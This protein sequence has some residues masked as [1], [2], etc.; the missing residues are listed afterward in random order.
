MNKDVPD[1]KFYSYVGED[2][3]R[4]W[5]GLERFGFNVPD[6]NDVNEPHE[7]GRDDEPFVGDPF[8]KGDSNF[9]K[10]IKG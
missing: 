8:D 7:G 1:A 5:R 3:K 9:Q 10:W 2:I 6:C 4:W